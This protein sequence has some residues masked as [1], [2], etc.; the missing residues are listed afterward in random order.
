MKLSKY[1]YISSPIQKGTDYGKIF[2][3]STRSSLSILM[4]PAIL[5]KLQ[6]KDYSCITPCLEKKLKKYKILVPNDENEFATVC[7][8]NS[9]AKACSDVLSLTIQPTANCQFGCHYC[10]QEHINHQMK[11]NV[12]SF[13]LNRIQRVLAMVP[14][15]KKVEITWY[16]GEPLLGL[17]VIQ[18]LSYQIQEL[19][20]EKGKQY[21]SDMVTNG[22][23]L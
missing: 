12:E 7:K 23:L 22:Y 21:R 6:A 11:K 20:R 1:L 3:F 19:C 13:C 2:V 15:Y 16:G 14:R 4:Q 17:S 9:I 5:K 10:G 18:S 8:E